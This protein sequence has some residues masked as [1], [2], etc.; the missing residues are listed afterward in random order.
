MVLA[1]PPKNAYAQEQRCFEVQNPAIT[2]CITG[3]FREFWET[4]G[5]LSAFGYPLGPATALPTA[6]GTYTIQYFERARFELHPENDPPYDVLLG[7]LGV[8]LLSARGQDWTELAPESE[9]ADCLFWQETLH[10]ICGPFLEAWRS[11]GVQL[12]DNIT[13]T[14]AEHLALWGLP[15]S[16]PQPTTTE[17][18][19]VLT[20]WFER[21]RIE[22][23]PNGSITFGRLGAELQQAPAAPPVEPPSAPPAQAAAP[24][25]PATPSVP[26]PSEPCNVNVPTPAE[27]LQIWMVD[28]APPRQTDAVA[29]VRLIVGGTAANGANAMAYRYRGT[30][31]RPSIP[32]STGRDGV[33]SFIFYI[34]EETGGVRIPVEAVVTYRGITYTAYSEFTPR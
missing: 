20:Q 23:Q 3:R 8:E 11:A 21:A 12:D 28:A 17:A 2:P 25:V 22:Q 9:A 4:N 19:V 33:A 31:R 32:Q 30:E 7:R 10:N 5:G 24:S 14:D 15:I 29:C 13:L 34:G 18:G 6:D 26:F 1:A 16:S 27:G